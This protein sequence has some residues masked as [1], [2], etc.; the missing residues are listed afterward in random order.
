MEQTSPHGNNVHA[1]RTLMAV[2]AYLG[3]LV[4]IPFLM[5]KDD[6]FVKFHIKQGLVLLVINIALWVLI[7]IS[8]QLWP[9][10]QLLN[11]G[12]LILAIIG[13]INAAQHKQNELPLVGG[14]ARNFNF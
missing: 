8:W 13:I 11:L 2:L 3:I 6:Q 12:V 1:N 10:F 7:S 9:L 5:A 14:F 4:L